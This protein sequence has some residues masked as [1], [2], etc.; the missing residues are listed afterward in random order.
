MI[1][2]DTRLLIWAVQNS[3]RV[4]EGLRSALNCEPGQAVFSIV[5]PWEIAL[6]NTGPAPRLELDGLLLRELLKANGFIEMPILAE[7]ALAVQHLPPIHKD[8]FDRMLIAQA[9]VEG[10]T[11]LT[12]DKTIARYPGPIELTL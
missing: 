9:M 3:P 5:T 7:H 12:A 6:K 11:L 2:F 1:L 8:P 4:C 10:M